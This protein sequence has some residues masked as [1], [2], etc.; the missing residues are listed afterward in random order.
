MSDVGYV[1]QQAKGNGGLRPSVDS[2]DEPDDL[3]DLTLAELEMGD[4]VKFKPPQDA[5][6]SE[7]AH[8]DEEDGEREEDEDGDE[9]RL[10]R[11]L[12]CR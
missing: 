12:W 4:F 1:P 5:E 7:N 2:D 9:V 8:G 11:I 10:S 6:E 3:L